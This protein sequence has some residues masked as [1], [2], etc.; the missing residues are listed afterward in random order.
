M[1]LPENV[2]TLL[3]WIAEVHGQGDHQHSKDIIHALLIKVFRIFPRPKVKGI[4]HRCFD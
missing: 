3:V 2:I 1:D 4:T